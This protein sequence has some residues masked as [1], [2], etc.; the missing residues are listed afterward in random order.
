[1]KR[2]CYIIGSN[3]PS[4]LAPLQYAR[5]GAEKIADVLSNKICQYETIIAREGAQARDIRDEL[6]SIAE[7]S[8]LCYFSGHGFIEKGELM[9][10]VDDSKRNQLLT[11]TLPVADLVRAASFCKARNKLLILDCCHAGAVVSMP[12]F[13]DF[14]GMPISELSFASESFLILM[15][16]GKLEK[17]R[18]SSSFPGGFLTSR[19]CYAL[20]HSEFFGS[21]DHDGDGVISTDDLRH[22]LESHAMTYNRNHEDAPL[23]IPEIFGRQKGPVYLT[24]GSR[25]LWQPVKISWPIG[26]EMVVLPLKPVVVRDRHYASCIS[27]TPITNAQYLGYLE[28]TGRPFPVGENFIRNE[29]FGEWQGPFEPMNEPGFS[30]PAHPV[31]C[32]SYD[33]A[34]NFC[35]WLNTSFPAELRSN[36]V[37]KLPSK[38]LWQFAAFG[39]KHPS[40]HRKSWLNQEEYTFHHKS[41]SPLVVDSSGER[42]NGYGVADL[43][44]NTWEWCQHEEFNSVNVAIAV[45][46][47]RIN[48][49]EKDRTDYHYFL[50]G[51]SF[52]DDLNTTQPVLDTYEDRFSG[53]TR[54]SDLG[55]RISCKVPLKLLDKPVQEMLQTF[56]EGE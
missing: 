36:A 49:G 16:S 24:L 44:G 1:M 22:F 14:G 13:K 10:L 45:L 7:S 18:E 3:G 42:T 29:K 26:I 6:F 56:N 8:F 34:T 30:D 37:A 51:G 35:K 41:N 5:K 53:T 39:T 52:L 38:D 25:H 32:V 31:V 12:G 28:A 50:R 33:D 54:H 46:Y 11:T 23:P 21:A 27:R 20:G 15:A 19:I 17:A 40:L 47:Y 48:P 9:L 2:I 4:D 55:F 43:I